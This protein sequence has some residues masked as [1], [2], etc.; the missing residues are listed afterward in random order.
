MAR[1]RGD[2]LALGSGDAG[3]GTPGAVPLNF[4]PNLY[5]LCK[6]I[7]LRTYYFDIGEK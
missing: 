7:F 5:K 6:V 3:D 2:A 4:A 1:R